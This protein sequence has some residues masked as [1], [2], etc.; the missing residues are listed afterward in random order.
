MFTEHLTAAEF[1]RVVQAA[2]PCGLLNVDRQLMMVGIS[3]T[4]VSARQRDPTPISQFQLDLNAMNQVE[5]LASGE[6]P[7][8]QFLRNLA[9]QGRLR[10]CPEAVVLEEF[11]N[12]VGNASSGT[13]TPP[14][15]TSLPEIQHNEAI[16][17][18]DDMVDFGF[19]SRALEVGKA[20]GRVLVPRYENGRAVMT[21]DR[22]PW[23]MR[24]TAWLV[25][26]DL[27]LTNHHV[28]NARR[29]E[30]PPATTADFLRQGSESFVEFD[31]DEPTAQMDTRTMK[32]VVCY[33]TALD[34]AL[35]RLDEPTGRSVVRLRSAPFTKAEVGTAV[36]IIQHPRG[37]AKRIAFRNNLV[38][39]VE[40]TVVRYYTDTD[41]GSSGS[42]V[43]DDNWR[44]VALHR[45]ARLA[46]GAN[47]Q[48]KSVA[49][50]N[51][52]S[53]IQTVLADIVVQSPVAA[54]EIKAGQGG[55]SLPAS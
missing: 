30:E 45:G 9:F 28:I 19:L 10:D 29:A 49:Y 27:V 5:R 48:G 40:D 54:T 16:V 37:E 53:Q 20:V 35:L 51:F 25:S 15:P 23:R 7:L 17:G 2:V 4:F 33:S 52:G 12:R 8:V 39:G 46:E 1:Q 38:S 32:E 55:S 26:P 21:S 18:F 24:G 22:V 3:P 34:Y 44:A 14:A 47:F 36:N 41:Y 13:P 11:A 43:C 6:V 50:V 42:P 31:F